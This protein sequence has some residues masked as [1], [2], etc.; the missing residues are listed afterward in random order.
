MLT[1]Y[2][3]RP[4]YR[5]TAGLD[6]TSSRLRIPGLGSFALVLF[7]A[8]AASSAFSQTTGTTVDG[9]G[10]SDSG[11][12]VTIMQYSGAGGAIIIKP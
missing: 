10:Y 11:G 4:H 8:H 2:F 6:R 9:F 3:D 1:P 7:V 5:M 12:A